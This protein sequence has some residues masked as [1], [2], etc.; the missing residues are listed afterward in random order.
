MMTNQKKSNGIRFA[1]FGT[2]HIAVYV[3]DALNATHQLPD[4]MI[5]QPAKP[6]GRGL[7]PKPTEVE[8][9]GLAHGIPVAH[10]SKEFESGTWDVAVVVDYGNFLPKHLLESKGQSFQMKGQNRTG[11]VPYLDNSI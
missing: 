8:V 6:Q 5:T 2:S 11:F 7:E 9:W 3:L 10:D 1:F 4:I